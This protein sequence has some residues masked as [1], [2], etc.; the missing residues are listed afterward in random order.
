MAASPAGTLAQ[1][2][3]A[4]GCAS[5]Q[6]ALGCTAAHGLDDARAVALSPDGKSLYVASATPASL[7]AFTADSRNG[8]LQQLNLG[9]G[10]LTSIPQADC[11]GARAL[12]GA[13]AVAVSPDGLHVYVAAAAAGGVA[14]FARQPNGSLVQ[15]L[16]IAGCVT[17]TLTPGC[18]NA[19]ALAGADAIAISPDGRFA[20]VGAA[21]ADAITA[22]SRDAATGRLTPLPGTAGCLRANRSTCT[23][24][25]G[26]DSPSA[27][28]ISPDGAS[29]Y[30]TSSA[31]TLTSFL[32]DATTGALTQLPAG[33]GC[34][35]DGPYDGCT[36]IGGLA[37][38]SAVAVSPDGSTVAAAGT[39]SDAVLTFRRDPATGALTRVAC[40]TGNPATAG[41]VLSTLVRGPRALAFRPDSRVV[42]VAS[43]RADSIVTLQL[44]PA[45][46][47]LTPTPGTGGCVRRQASVECRAARSLDDPRGLALSPDGLRLFAVSALS[48]GIAVLGPQLA[49]NCLTTRAATPANKARSVVLACSDPNGD[50]VELTI[51]KQP[52]HGKLSALVKATGT[53]LYTPLPGYTGTDTFSYRA[54]DGMDVSADGAAT[55]RVTLPTKAPR[56]RIRTARTRLLRGAKIHV[57]VECPA[58]AIGPCR[59]ATHLV[60]RGQA[61]GY[62]FASLARRTTGRIVLRADGVTGRTRAQVVV[63]VRDK[64]RRATISRRT[65]L[66]VP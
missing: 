23:P 59:I 7:T 25:S 2:A 5:M 39:D 47:A 43:S 22:F 52:L 17:T 34:L 30:V 63:T 58:I 46:G 29:L 51:V 60:V 48:D 36:P 37:R 26:V 53:V 11:S 13:S 33:P 42:W 55:V 12:E 8:L 14:S 38:A 66:I 3:G 41:C 18:A 31:G 64:T 61:A 40:V 1:T 44:D 9:A 4:G 62:G 27:I 32:R 57:L 28:A 21:S 10:C 15:L 20:Y 35:S 54:S 49:P 50:T 16:G 56:V 19:P 45:T 65:I 6:T 24:V